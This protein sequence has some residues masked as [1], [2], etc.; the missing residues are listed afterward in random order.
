MGNYQIFCMFIN[1]F[2]GGSVHID[3]LITLMKSSIVGNYVATATVKLQNESNSA[4]GHEKL[5][6]IKNTD[7]FAEINRMVKKHA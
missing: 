2:T 6:A 3:D 5:D 7:F 1:E 4:V